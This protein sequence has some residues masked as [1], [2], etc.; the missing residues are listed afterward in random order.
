MA[1][2]KGAPP[3]LM[4]MD[5]EVRAITREQFAGRLR[6]TVARLHRYGSAGGKERV[7]T[8][9]ELERLLT[10][11]K[12]FYTVEGVSMALRDD[13][14]KALLLV[15]KMLK[16]SLSKTDLG[17]GLVLKEVGHDI[18]MAE[19]MELHALQKGLKDGTCPEGE[20]SAWHSYGR[21]IFE[22]TFDERNAPLAAALLKTMIEPQPAIGGAGKRRKKAKLA[23]APGDM[24]KLVPPKVAPQG[25]VAQ[26]HRRASG[27]GMAPPPK[28][29]FADL[30]QAWAGTPVGGA[31]EA[32]VAGPPRSHARQVNADAVR[33]HLMFSSLTPSEQQ[34][35]MRKICK[36]IAEFALDSAAQ[37]KP[38]EAMAMAL[39][40]EQLSHGTVGFFRQ[41]DKESRHLMKESL[42]LLSKS[43]SAAL[44]REAKFALQQMTPTLVR[45]GLTAAAAGELLQG[46]P[47][48]TFVV[49]SNAYP[50]SEYTVFVTA[51]E[52]VQHF[53]VEESAAQNGGVVYQFRG[54]E[55]YSN[56]L[57]MVTRELK[58]KA[59]LNEHGANPRAQVPPGDQ[60][61]YAALP[62]VNG[63]VAGAAAA[64]VPVIGKGKKF[65]KKQVG[66]G[67]SAT[68]EVSG[69]RSM[70]SAIRRPRAGLASFVSPWTG[71]ASAGR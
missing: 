9:A 32:K 55:R 44:S 5:G 49:G 6:S 66:G 45:P 37:E 12:T 20:E 8:R 14:R 34:A 50:G 56:L 59:G 70:L 39:E 61:A 17:T 28:K 54:G 33:L 3:A 60:R 10:Q 27:P 67:E 21:G 1:K 35:L 47:P 2:I 24:E 40:L 68:F 19:R 11:V 16:G 30:K 38:G 63:A 48:G 65:G 52:G 57:T 46:E 18:Y 26:R 13:G 69:A 4:R 22:H 58:G 64:P 36:G 23:P 71:M 25:E 29:G 51:L 42:A 15:H 43:T 62:E 31:R 7:E 41:L 53:E